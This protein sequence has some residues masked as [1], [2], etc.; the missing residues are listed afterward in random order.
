MIVY[1]SSYGVLVC[2]FEVQQGVAQIATAAAAAASTNCYI[3]CDITMRISGL[4]ALVLGLVVISVGTI[5]RLFLPL[6]TNAIFS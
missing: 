6:C 4:I 5:I 1:Q 2:V 3:V